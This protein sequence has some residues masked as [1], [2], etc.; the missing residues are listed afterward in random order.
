MGRVLQSFTRSRSASAPSQPEPVLTGP[1]TA[2]PRAVRSTAT[3]C[4]QSV[5]TGQ[6][7]ELVHAGR[8]SSEEWQ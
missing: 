8:G 3:A 6:E 5:P 7:Q 4:L 2:W 1:G